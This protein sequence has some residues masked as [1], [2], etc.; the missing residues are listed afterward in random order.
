MAIVDGRRPGY[1]TGADLTEMADFMLAR[2]AVQ[3]INLD[4]G[5]SAGLLVRKPGDV[6]ASFAN[7]VSDLQERRISNALLLVSSSA[8]GPVSTVALT[9]SE[10]R[11]FAGQ[12]A[13]F[14]AAAH[15]VAFNGIPVTPDNLQWS[16]EGSGGLLDANGVFTATEQGTATVTATVE[17]VSAAAPVAVLD[18]RSAPVTQPPTAQFALDSTVA[19]T[20]VPVRVSWPEADEPEGAV[21][22]YELVM[23]TNHGPYTA[24]SLPGPLVRGAT[25][26]LAQQQTYR[27]AVRAVDEAGN[28]GAWAR[29]TPLVIGMVQETHPSVTADASWIAQQAAPFLR[30]ATRRSWTAGGTLSV[31]LEGTHFGWIGARGPNRGRAEVWLDGTHVATVDLSAPANQARQVVYRR[32]LG[33]PGSHVVEIRHLGDPSGS[34]ID[35]DGFLV[36]GPGAPHPVI[37]GAGD[38]ATCTRTT[39]DATA[40]LLDSIVGTVVTAGDN[41]YP[42]GTAAEFR[43]CYGPSWGRVKARTRPTPGNHDFATTAASG[44]FGYFGAAAGSRGKGW[45]A[46]D[47]GTWRVYGLNSNCA[48]V[49]GCGEGSA[50]LAWLRADLAARPHACVLALWHH[51]RFS[52]GAHGNNSVSQPLFA[53]L[54]AAGAD[55]VLTGHDHHYE[56]F[57]PQTATGVADPATGIRQ[58]VVGTGGNGLYAV[59]AA[60]PNSEV[61]DGTSLGVLQLTLRPGAYDWQFLPVPGGTNTDSGTAACHA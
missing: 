5:G 59:G 55:V 38:I 58:F 44:Y 32:S 10:A 47:L 39:D 46:Y 35:V 52:S 24:V 51:A 22:R 15:D 1:S 7:V 33:A 56:R 4:G 14:D 53:A 42:N 21:A 43:D 34:R 29:T 41:A 16:V 3:A 45:Y 12:T 48:F 57:A 23:S 19:E 37:V 13:A 36:V 31:T 25:L 6:E 30:G 50:Q 9:P 61:R 27:F 49:G 40:A 18:D 28:V 17:G 54:H 26:Q 60:R 2:G 8:T 11:L 20:S